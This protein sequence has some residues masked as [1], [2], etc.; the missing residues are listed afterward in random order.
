MTTLELKAPL[1][2]LLMPIE[3]VPDPVFATKLLGDGVALD[4]TSNA[5]LAPCEGHVIELHDAHHALTIA[6]PDG[7][8]IL[9]HIGLDTVSLGGEGFLPHVHKGDFVLTGQVLIEF[10]PD[11][12]AQY[13]PSLLTMIVVAN[14]EAVADF[15][16][17]HGEA[18]A[19][20]TVIMNLDLNGH[21]PEVE[22]SALSTL[23]LSSLPVTIRNEQGLHAR[24][25]AVLAGLAHKF[26]SQI[27]LRKG[28]RSADARSIVGMMKLNVGCNDAV[29]LEAAGADA[30]EAI[31]TLVTAVENGL[32]E[33]GAEAIPVPASVAQEAIN[34]P[35]PRLRF[36]AANMILG[37]AASPGLAVGNVYQFRHR[38]IEVDE[39]GSGDPQAERAA[40]DK[41]ISQSA[42]ELEALQAHLLGEGK[43]A[44]AAIFAAHQEMLRDP[45]LLNRAQE[46][47]DKGY[48]AAYGWLVA[49]NTQAG[50]L[51]ETGNE[52]LAARAADLRETGR[53]VLAHLTGAHGV[54]MVALPPN[55]ILIAEDLTLADVAN[56]DRDRVAGFATVL[57]GA[58]SQ[59]A[60]LARSLDIP[61]IAGIEAR[62]LDLPNGTPLI[63]DATRARIQLNPK[64]EEIAYM[65]G[66]LRKRRQKRKA[67]L[68][69]A[70]NPALTKDG[71]C[72]EI[73]AAIS[74]EPEAEQAVMLGAEGVGL[75]RTEFL[76][77]NR[78]SA[79]N[80][81]EQAQ[82]YAA[83][84][85]VMGRKKPTI[86]R[87]LNIDGDEPLPYLPVAWQKNA[88]YGERGIRIGLAHP[89]LL[90]TQIR[91]ILRASQAGGKI[92]ILL[93]MI[94]TLDE[95][96]IA[97]AII[98]EE[99][100][101]LGVKPVPVGIMA[102]VPAVAVMAEQFARE[103]DF[104]SISSN[105][106]AQYTLAMDREHPKLAPQVDGLNPAVLRLIAQTLEGA[107]KHGRWVGVCGGL[108]GDPQAVPI[109]LGLG[110][111]A[112]SPAIAAIPTIKA[113]VRALTYSEA[114]QTAAQ[115]LTL[116]SAAEVRALYP[117]EDYEL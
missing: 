103:V 56:L 82:L 7:V 109:L 15:G 62:A 32:G 19:G 28:D 97:R 55:T 75:L 100:H 69:T 95:W 27:Y 64:P 65:V 117:L 78:R 23:T 5:L 39:G 115:A 111:K 46:S 6:T 91:A 12:V 89:F 2:G 13:A 67:D 71:R 37:A 112:L 86:I 18:T 84:A 88:F 52:L 73:L 94:A 16:K 47:I 3:E 40:L 44:K 59:V 108:T 35:A 105:D 70:P 85:G 50:R 48:S 34:A 63:L 83:I 92:Q 68:E 8:E 30:Q 102:G 54:E 81:E 51:E 33:E 24:P 116:E 29:I 31:N 22:S 25:A 72:L 93:P 57:G 80:E 74:G 17:A 26:S 58:T 21:A 79:P 96:R 45:V 38:E 36:G 20:R 41:A 49:T 110:V 10:N 99:A 14:S 43:P 1:S 98:E 11:Y 60:I 114:R 66:M 106:L 101:D 90:R 104:F 53:R 113:L 9:L 61:A 107:E 77:R 42:L 4:P 76:F 87:T